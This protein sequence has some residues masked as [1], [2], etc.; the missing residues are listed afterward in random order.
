M[1]LRRISW[2]N[3]FIWG[4]C[5]TLGLFTAIDLWAAGTTPSSPVEYDTYLSR[6]V[7]YMKSNFTRDTWDLTMRWLNFLILVAI[8]V[9]YARAPVINF[10][11]GKRTEMARAI[12]LVEEKKRLAEEKVK[13]RQIQ[14]EASQQRLKLLRD[15]IVSE[16]QRRKE[17]II[18]SAKQE[19]RIM[20]ESARA[21]VDNQINDAYQIIRQELVEIAVDKA[22]DRLP[23][24]LTEQDHQR[25]ID[26]W[27]Q[28][29]ER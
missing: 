18:V 11:K 27:M 28:E 17:Q 29:A 22:M 20:M 4:I 9:K 25:M 8:I 26:I 21:K 5:L 15:R 19:S 24:M 13:E 7:Q 1:R 6:G 10:L 3:G 16:G 12:E 14:L 2:L 23:G